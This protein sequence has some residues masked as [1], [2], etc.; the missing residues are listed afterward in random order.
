MSAPP[1]GRVYRMN[2]LFRGFGVAFLLFGTFFLFA[3]GRELFDGEVEPNFIKI[4][5]AFVFSL[6]G[7]G[8]TV[9]GFVSK[10]VFSEDRVYKVSYLGRKSLPFASIRGRRE[11]V[12]RGNS[13]SG[14]TRYLRLEPNDSHPALE[15]GKNLYAF[16]AAFMEWFNTLPDL[17]AMDKVQHK[18]SNFGLV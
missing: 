2:W 9:H 6:V 15:F 10:L 4:G 14:S 8:I 7:F 3:A 11:F 18:D 5:I 13:E 12:V 17:D 16:D 1:I